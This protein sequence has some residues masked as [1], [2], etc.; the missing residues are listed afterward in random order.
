MS[1]K[2]NKL[3][4]MNPTR[5]LSHCATITANEWSSLDHDETLDLWTVFRS[6]ILNGYDDT[7]IGIPARISAVWGRCKDIIDKEAK[8]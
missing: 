8:Q 5:A 3:R 2:T 6:Y 4:S 7:H 1:N